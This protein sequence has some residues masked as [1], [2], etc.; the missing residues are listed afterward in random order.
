MSEEDGVTWIAPNTS[1]GY[2]GVSLVTTPMPTFQMKFLHDSLTVQ[3]TDLHPASSSR[4][5]MT[6]AGLRSPWVAVDL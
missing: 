1:S 2:N 5:T 4:W 3:Q 6:F